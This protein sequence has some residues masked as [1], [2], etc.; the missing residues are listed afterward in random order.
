M[1]SGRSRN[2]KGDAS[3]PGGRL[4]FRVRGARRADLDEL[5]ALEQELFAGDRLSR[6]SFRRFVDSPTACLLVGA[7]DDRL[8]GYALILFRSGSQC[9]RLYGIGRKP[10]STGGG[11]G[12]ALLGAAEAA[13]RERHASELR[14]EVRSDNQRAHDFYRRHGFH[15][16]DRRSRYYEDGADALRMK[17]SLDE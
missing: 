2:V 15:V 6:R 11:I 4:V 3:S 5:T 16:F 7:A 10:T 17:K 1:V 14:L 8:L 9:A 12:T 13:A